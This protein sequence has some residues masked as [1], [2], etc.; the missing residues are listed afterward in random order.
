MATADERRRAI[1]EGR[2]A[3]R[4]AIEG[5]ADGWDARPAGDEWTRRKTAEHAIAVE[6]VF[7][8]RAEQAAAGETPSGFGGGDPAEPAL[9]GA[10]EALAALD[11]AAAR[12]DAAWGAIGDAQLAIELGNGA[13]LDRVM[14]LTA[15]HL[16]EH[17]EQI[18]A[19]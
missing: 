10:T 16:A 5:A 11:A 14:E 2:A 4:A 15:L 3:F 18:A 8:A 6:H 13:T 1:A 12:A 17:A 19:S 9:A 7:A